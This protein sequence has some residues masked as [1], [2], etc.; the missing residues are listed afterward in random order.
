MK[1]CRSSIHGWGLYA[2]EMIG[3]DEVIIEYIGEKVR[4]SIA[5]F[6]EHKYQ[7]MGIGSS[8]MFRIDD[9]MVSC[10]FFILGFFKKNIFY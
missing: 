6:R 7:K 5:D 2:D 9:E 1:F 8:Y 10:K 3:P 4:H